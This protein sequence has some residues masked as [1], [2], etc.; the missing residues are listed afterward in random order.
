MSLSPKS[1][2]SIKSLPVPSRSGRKKKEFESLELQEEKDS[3]TSQMSR[4][5]LETPKNPKSKKKS[6]MLESPPTTKKKTSKD[7]SKSSKNIT[8]ITESSKILDR[9]S[10]SKE[11]ALKPFWTSVSRDLSM[12]LWLPTKIDYVDLDLKSSNSSS[13]DLKFDSWFSVKKIK[14]LKPLQNKNSLK[15]FYP[16]LRSLLPKTM[17]LEQESIGELK[18]KKLRLYPKKKAKRKINEWIGATRWIYNKC[19]EAVNSGERKCNLKELRELISSEEEEWLTEI[20]YEIKDGAI[21]D[22]VKAGKATRK[23][24]KKFSFKSRKDLQQSFYLR[25]RDFFRKKGKF[26][27][28]GEIK[29]REELPELEHDL[30]LIKDS[31]NRY[32]LAIPVPL[33]IKTLNESQVKRVVSIDPG[34]RTFATC[35]DP[36][37]SITEWG[38]ND[39][40]RLFRLCLKIDK[41]TSEA[42]KSNAKRRF[43]LRKKIKRIRSKIRNLVDELHRKLAKW[44]CSNYQVILLPEFKVQGMAKK[45]KRKISNKSVRKMMTLSHYRFKQFLINKVREYPGVKVLIVTEEFTSKTCGRCGVENNKLGSSKLFE[46]EREGCNLKIDRDHNGARNILIKTLT[47]SKMSCS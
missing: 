11:E 24:R 23:T 43:V 2:K 38:V 21:R 9:E 17:D 19:V 1:K 36:Q 22:L 33:E 16:S 45:S 30:R 20:P 18:V 26:S 31:L 29:T 41:Y 15:T 12:K 40:E 35:Y 46:C 27:F 10:I 5:S 13:K 14:K 39:Q 47:E 34:N 32:W 37:G 42:S 8:Q 6:V 7:K 3:I 28:L 44:L 25:A 4:N